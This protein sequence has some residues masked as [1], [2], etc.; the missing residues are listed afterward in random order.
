MET[1]T[2]TK[3]KLYTLIM[4]IN[5]NQNYIIY[6]YVLCIRGYTTQCNT[7]T[8]KYT[9]WRILEGVTY[10]TSMLM[11]ESHWRGMTSDYSTML[12]FYSGANQQPQTEPSRL[13]IHPGQPPTSSTGLKPKQL[14]E[15]KGDLLRGSNM[16]YTPPKTNISPEKWWLEDETSFWHSHR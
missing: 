9:F 10:P 6:E 1:N 8:P 7:G 12:P 13:G 16:K 2:G 3:R 11:I 4:Q 5:Y 14:G 15:C